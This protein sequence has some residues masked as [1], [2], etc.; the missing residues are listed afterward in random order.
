[1][2]RRDF[3]AA[4]PA[5]ALAA[6]LPAAEPKLAIG[7]NDWPWWRGPTRDGV[8]AAQKIPLEWSATKNVLWQADVPGRVP[9]P[10]ISVTSA[11][12]GW[13]GREMLRPRG[14]RPGPGVARFR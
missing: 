11:P 2:D 9:V 1:M 6:Q 14:V 7:P 4:L 12:G 5:C 13:P 10:G 8:A 3:L